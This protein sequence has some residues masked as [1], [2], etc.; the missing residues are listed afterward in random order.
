MPSVATPLQGVAARPQLWRI[1]DRT[2]FS[3]LRRRG[4][5][6]RTGP[7]T[8]TWLP[9]DP[10]MPEAPPRAAFA[11]G[12]GAG[13]VTRNR[14]RRRL[15][16]ALRELQRRDALPAGSYLVGA[17]HD[18]ARQPWSELVDALAEA[19]ATATG[20]RTSP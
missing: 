9:A 7:L 11:V 18:V 6:A 19:V 20:P 12:K 13:A 1:S 3:D 14:I 8:V 16:A 17:T 4:R 15:R 2:T 5:R 10:A